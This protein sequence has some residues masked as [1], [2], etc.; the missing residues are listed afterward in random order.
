MLDLQTPISE[1]I[2]SGPPT[3]V[4]TGA[5]VAEAAQAMRE[6]DVGCVFVEHDGKLVGIFTER[7]FLNRVAAPHKSLESV[8]VG[9]VMTSEPDVLRAIDEIAWAIHKMAVGGFRNVPVVDGEHRPVGVVSAHD[10][11]DF[12]AELFDEALSGA[13]AGED[14][15]HWTDIGGG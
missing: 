7:D 1:F 8:R 9:E 13:G 15:H 4:T 2:K 14:D 12:L 10:V 6:S 5:S 3:T 11:I